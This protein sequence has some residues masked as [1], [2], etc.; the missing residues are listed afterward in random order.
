VLVKLHRFLGD[1]NLMQIPSADTPDQGRELFWPVIAQMLFVAVIAMVFARQA[2]AALGH[3]DF[4]S[5]WAAHHVADPYDSRT[6]SNA[7]GVPQVTEV[8][9]AV[10]PYP[11]TFLLMTAPL[12]WLSAF[13]G[14]RAWLALS[15]AVLVLALRRPIGIAIIFVPTVFI[16][17]VIGQSSL[18]VAALLFGAATTLSRPVVAGALFG[19][20]AC[21]KP[22]VGLL[23]PFVLLGGGHWRAIVVAGATSCGLALAATAVYGAGVWGRWLGSLP[24][25]LSANDLYLHSH[26]I[27]L[28]GAWRVVALLFGA[29]FAWR[30][31]RNGDP[32]IGGMIAISG[33]LLGSLHAMNY[34]QAILA[35]FVLAAALQRGRWGLPYF[36]LLTAPASTGATAALGILG[37]I[38]SCGYFGSSPSRAELTRAR[39]FSWSWIVQANSSRNIGKG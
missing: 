34:D 17:G 15:L 21:V 16:A 10:F 28:P 29:I 25:F 39:P 22:Q 27:S 5:F 8:T 32:L 26:F 36:A 23:I 33:A 14:F 12:Q 30:A 19:L 24:A 31:G 37:C 6:I 38:D 13:D 3:P 2:F 18:L 20:A 35:P 9:T 4:L 1:A 7:M 11:P